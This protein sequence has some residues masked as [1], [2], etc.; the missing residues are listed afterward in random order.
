MDRFVVKRARVNTTD[1]Q[2]ASNNNESKQSTV[3]AFSTFSTSSTI[4]SL[5]SADLV[6]INIPQNDSTPNLMTASSSSSQKSR[7]FRVEWTKTYQ[8]LVFDQETSRAFCKIC[9]QAKDMQLLDSEK[10]AKNAFTVDG[11]RDWKHALERFKGHETSDSHR[12]SVT[13]LSFVKAGQN[14]ASCLSQCKRDE[15]ALARKALHTIFTSLMFLA[16]QGIAIR[17]K[18]DETSNLQQLLLLRSADVDCLRT[19]LARCQYKWMSHDIQ[20]EILQL[21]AD[22]ILRQLLADVRDAQYFALMVDETTDS[23]RH[24]QLVF[25]IRYCD[26]KL[27]THELFMGFY[28]LEQQDANTLLKVVTD[29]LLRFNLRESNCRGQCYDGAANVAGALNGLQS[30]IRR[31]ENRAIYVHCAAHSLNL[32]VQDAIAAISAYR[33][34]LNQFGTLINFVRDS[35][36]R[37]RWF[38][39]L[40]HND[41]TTLRPYCPTRWVLRENA[42]SSVIANYV[43]LW[44]FMEDLGQSDKS[45]IGAKATGFASQLS[46]FQTYFHLKSLHK[47]FSAVG[48]VNQA[49]QSSTLHLQQASRMISDL[50]ELLQNFRDKFS[51]LWSDIQQNAS[52]LG[53]DE[54][55]LPRIRRFP[56]RLDEGSQGH[57]FDTAEEYYRHQYLQLVDAAKAAIDN[58]F[59]SDT[60][61]FLSSA[62]SALVTV[63]VDTHV[64]S[65]FYGSDIDE[66]R[67]NLHATM[68]HDITHHRKLQMNNVGDI[69]SIF[70]GDTSLCTLLPEMV[71][72]LRLL[73]TV[74]LTTCTAERSFSSLRRLK[75]YLRSTMTQRRLNNIA[76]LHV[77]HDYVQNLSV[78]SLIDEFINRNAIRQSTFA[79]GVSV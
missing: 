62:E 41:A 39:K 63:P 42:L 72:V 10:C 52:R 23:S 24:E 7:S 55:T 32:C 28:E 29:V 4:S 12:C 69:I 54:P 1:T 77:H 76:V 74:P 11:F 15:M 22:N 58:R 46:R 73:L 51:E 48:T 79:V 38:E 27:D 8:W 16:R 78:D 36:K 13:K 30:K 2:T 60:W 35:P 43:E 53:L 57:V 9:M 20:N 37:L 31:T 67:L 70:R 44:Q 59:A 17:G 49:M 61:N 33:D 75:T 56:R 65:N 66:D 19:W 68:L 50:K 45:D 26:Q 71:K 6:E 47:V 5:P 64:I 18:I 40:Q 34:A 3:T 21:M 25:C 14:V